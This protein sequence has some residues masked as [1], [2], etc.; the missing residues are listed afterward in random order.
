MA[1]EGFDDVVD[2][3]RYECCFREEDEEGAECEDHVVQMV[4][5]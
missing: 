2:S 1:F 4:L 5:E 3:D